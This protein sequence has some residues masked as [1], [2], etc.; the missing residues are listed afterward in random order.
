MR[1]DTKKVKCRPKR[2]AGAVRLTPGGT[3][4]GALR[5][6]V[7]VNTLLSLPLPRCL[8]LGLLG[9]AAGTECI[10]VAGGV[11]ARDGPRC[12]MVDL[13]LRLK[14]AAREGAVA[15]GVCTTPPLRRRNINSALYVHARSVEGLGLIA[16]PVKPCARNR[17]S[18]LVG[19]LNA[20]GL[21][22]HAAEHV[23]VVADPEAPPEVTRERKDKELEFGLGPYSER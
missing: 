15:E 11:V 14:S 4:R 19:A 17:L 9:V 16:A 23:L 10:Q 18:E 21:D 1:Q 8:E 6:L 12:T 22:A 20:A 3:T 13:P 2:N 7:G 5:L